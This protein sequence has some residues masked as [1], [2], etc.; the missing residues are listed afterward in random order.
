MSSSDAVSSEYRDLARQFGTM[1][2]KTGRKL[3]YG[4][5]NLG[6]MRDLAEAAKANG[7]PITGVIPQF[8]YELNLAAP[9]EF[10][11]DLIITADLRE[12]KAKMDEHCDAFVILPGGLGTLEEA[13]EAFNLKFLRYHAKPVVFLDHNRFYQPLFDLLSHFYRERF[14][15]PDVEKLCARVATV[16]ECFEYLDSY[17]PVEVG[18]KWFGK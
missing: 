9:S 7:A 11:D 8:L 6:L 17:E 15:K 10:Y 12:R 5:T 13:L 4:G 1:I 2:G 18:L 3:V 16:D 14:T